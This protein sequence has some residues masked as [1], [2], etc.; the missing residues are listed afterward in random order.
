MSSEIDAPLADVAQDFSWLLCRMRHRSQNILRPL[1][2]EL[3][4]SILGRTHLDSES[5]VELWWTVALEAALFFSI[6][7]WVL[8]VDSAWPGDNPWQFALY[9]LMGASSAAIL[10]HLI[11][12]VCEPTLE[13]I[14]NIPAGRVLLFMLGIW[15]S[16][17]AAAAFFELAS[18]TGSTFVLWRDLPLRDAHHEG[19]R[20]VARLVAVVA[21]VV[22][23]V[24]VVLPTLRRLVA[25]V[26]LGI[27]ISLAVAS[28]I[29]Q[30]PALNSMNSHMQSEDGLGD[31]RST[32]AKAMLL[33]SAPAAIL[34][35]RIGR[36]RLSLRQVALTGFWGAWLPL[37][38]SVTLVSVAKMCGVRLYWKPSLPLDHTWAFV[39]LSVATDRTAAF[40]WP[41]GATIGAPLLILATWITD[42]GRNWPWNWQKVSALTAVGVAGYYL[43]SPVLWDAASR[44]WLWSIILASVLL[45]VFHLLVRVRQSRARSS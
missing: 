3:S 11:P 30:Y 10:C 25:S 14:W 32:V 16:L 12:A 8:T 38:V 18:L 43:R 41:L 24:A 15:L 42:I 2:R 5:T 31:A 20:W 33:A 36:M 26:C 34:G 21:I 7:C 6:P 45:G 22:S 13:F 35:L 28:V 37:L 4:L 23:F 19:W 29:A 1:L 17:G 27:G 40:L 44:S 39:W 9:L